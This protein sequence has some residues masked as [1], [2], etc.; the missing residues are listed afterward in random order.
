MREHIVV[1]VTTFGEVSGLHIKP[2][3]C[4]IIPIACRLSMHVV[5]VF[6]NWINT[7]LPEWNQIKIAASGKYL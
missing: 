6:R 5:E 7:H 4:V 1:I 3:K 2:G